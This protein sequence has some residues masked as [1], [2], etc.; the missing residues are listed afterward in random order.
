MPPKKKKA[1]N[2]ESA[3]SRLEEIT[4]DLESGKSSLEQSIELYSEGLSLAKEC[5][6]KLSAAEKKIKLI[7]KKNDIEVEEDFEPEEA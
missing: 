7:A 1:E 5:H 2:F 6:K 3:L 4:A